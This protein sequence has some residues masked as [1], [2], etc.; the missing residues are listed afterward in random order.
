MLRTLGFWKYP[1]LSRLGVNDAY[2]EKQDKPTTGVNDACWKKQDK[3][4]CILYFPYATCMIHHAPGA[5]QIRRSLT[6]D[7]RM[8]GFRKSVH[9]DD[10]HGTHK[11]RFGAS[12]ITTETQMPVD[13][14]FV[15]D[16]E[17]CVD[18]FRWNMWWKFVKMTPFPF[19]MIGGNPNINI[20][21]FIGVLFDGCQIHV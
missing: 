7:G 8:V 20:D 6:D 19:Q 10:R 1:L 16:T 5:V 15:T 4:V 13:K 17:R 12:L 2:C 14:I 3:A 18:N 11:S 21:N 9:V